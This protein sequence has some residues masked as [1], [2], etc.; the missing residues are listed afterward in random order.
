MSTGFLTLFSPTNDTVT[1]GASGSVN[2]TMVNDEGGNFINISSSGN[3]ISIINESAG[4]NTFVFSGIGN[5]IT[6]PI[7]N[8]EV[9]SGDASL[10]EQFIFNTP[11][12]QIFDTVDF[13]KIILGSNSAPYTITLVAGTTD[14]ISVLGLNDDI[15]GVLNSVDMLNGNTMIDLS[16]IFQH[17][18]QQPFALDLTT[19]T[20]AWT[21]I[22]DIILG[23]DNQ[24]DLDMYSIHVIGADN[25]LRIDANDTN[26]S[27]N[28]LSVSELQGWILGSD[29]PTFT[30]LNGI[31]HTYNVYTASTIFGT[32]TLM[33]D[34]N[35][36][37]F[38]PNNPAT[39]SG[40]SSGEVTENSNLMGGNLVAQGTL[41]VHDIDPGQDVFQ[42]VT[43]QAGNYG[44]FSIDATG[45]WTYTA[46]NSQ[47]A[48]QALGLGDS[49]I[50]TFVVHSV[51]GTASQEV[52]VTIAGNPST[53]PLT[54]TPTSA[55]QSGSVNDS[56]TVG[57]ASGGT[58][59]Y[60]YAITATGTSGNTYNF[61]E[62]TLTFALLALGIY[63][64]TVTTTDSHTPSGTSTESSF[65]LSVTT[66]DLTNSDPSV[67]EPNFVQGQ[68]QVDD[69]NT[70]DISFYVMNGLQALTILGTKN[71]DTFNID[72]ISGSTYVGGLGYNT[73]S[74]QNVSAQTL[75]IIYDGTALTG[76]VNNGINTDTISGFNEFDANSNPHFELTNAK[77]L[78]INT[79]GGSAVLDFTN[80][81][82]GN[83]LNLIDGG[84]V[85][86][87]QSNND[88]INIIT[89]S[90]GVFN[91][92]D[93]TGSNFTNSGSTITMN[94]T[95][96][97]G[98]NSFAV[99]SSGENRINLLDGAGG[100]TFAFYSDVLFT[101]TNTTPDTS[102]NLFYLDGAGTMSFVGTSYD[103]VYSWSGVGNNISFSGGTSD[104]VVVLNFLDTI[105]GALNGNTAID[106][107]SLFQGNPLTL[108]YTVDALPA[109]TNIAALILPQSTELDINTQVIHEL[110]SS[111]SLALD[112]ND[113]DF[114]GDTLSVT[115][116]RWWTLGTDHPTATDINGVTHTYNVYTAFTMYGFETLMVD[117]NL[118]G[119][120]P[121]SSPTTSVSD[122]LGQSYSIPARFF[123]TLSYANDTTD[124]LTINW[125]GNAFTGSVSDGTLS[126]PFSG[127]AQVISNSLGT[128]FN[129][130]NFATML[131]ET[132]GGVNSFLVTG[133]DFGGNMFNLLGGGTDSFSGAIGDT[134]NV[135]NSSDS[136]NY[137]IQIENGT[138]DISIYANGTGNNF[139][140]LSQYV[141]ADVLK[142]D[143]NADQVL[144]TLSSLMIASV[145]NFDNV[146]LGSLSSIVNGNANTLNPLFNEQGSVVDISAITGA[147][148]MNNASSVSWANIAGIILGA[149]T[150]L[151]I[152]TTAFASISTPN[153]TNPSAVNNPV[154]IE[155][156]DVGGSSDSVTATGGWTPMTGTGSQVTFNDSNGVAHVYVGYQA[157]S[158]G[159]VSETLY[160]DSHIS[161]QNTHIS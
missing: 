56:I 89:M 65:D 34:E 139:L 51:D 141:T 116:T 147:V 138:S 5:T 53:S 137:I 117:E 93:I 63:N 67:I 45:N 75:T 76:T 130:S 142:V 90:G 43:S 70:R 79:S 6:Q 8:S 161:T 31:T 157:T 80:D 146:K 119:F 61:M 121:I 99:M 29:H 136:N 132:T 42:A 33:V 101:Q 73:I 155:A 102:T 153:A 26:F 37:G 28:T 111:N 114:S 21:N 17:N 118:T 110:G 84:V 108:D 83:I 59:P 54:F 62:S 30:D 47:A 86:I 105:S 106:M 158:P 92:S 133:T 87:N 100:N 125:N 69:L 151:N 77:D 82:G 15:L 23:Q 18:G 95:D 32:E 20:P 74:Y 66:L 113:T 91:A 10:G 38:N 49:L 7:L 27:G 13:S 40:T 2:F 123:G 78:V 9:L 4:Q 135:G 24:L 128:T 55:Q 148:N 22:S 68:V 11:G 39:I 131:Y 35:L 58:P 129:L 72:S 122:V 81:L 109:W 48:V 85:T 145:L 19:N 140:D 97:G 44:N 52:D 57:S 120:N 159:G 134:I 127:F 96:D 149:N 50:D 104:T 98:G 14:A 1:G 160:V 103:T 41:T 126:D 144:D 124:Q 64:V 71:D 112:A 152:D 94:I 154:F 46:D 88:T 16:A 150:S 36:P 143:F 25:T 12:V 115:Q 3:Q 156:T 60:S 107:G